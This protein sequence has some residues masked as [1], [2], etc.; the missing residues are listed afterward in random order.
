MSD[1]TIQSVA[2]IRNTLPP[3]RLHSVPTRKQ[4]AV[5]LV[6]ASNV[7]IDDSGAVA[8]RA[9]Q[10]LESANVAH[11]LWSNADQSICL[12]VEGSS[13]KRLMTVG[14]T[15][16]TLALGLTSGRRMA[17]V[18]VNDRV[19]F[20]NGA[21]TGVID[22]S[23]RSWGIAATEAPAVSAIAGQLGAGVY[24]AAYTHLRRD[25]QESGC[26]LA[27][28]IT[29][30]D[31]A[32]VRFTWNAPEDADVDEVALYLSE[33]NG[34]VMYQAGVYAAAALSADVTGPAL[35][36]PLATQWLDAPPPGQCLALHNGRI[37]IGAG[38]FV[39]GTGA[40]DFEHC[41]LRDYLALDGSAVRFI[42]GVTGG[43][44]IGTAQAVY[45]ASGERLESYTLRKVSTAPAV[46]GSVVTAN[47]A[48][49][50]GNAEL[51]PHEV[52]LFTTAEGVFMGLPDG[53]VQNLTQERYRFAPGAEGAAVFR[54]EPTR[55]QYLLVLPI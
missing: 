45:F 25:G 55:H 6:Q 9:G 35:A 20:S 28:Q 40:L 10:T 5:D 54:E 43:L 29:L 41:D 39:F 24:Q 32:G 3:E 15:V 8:R 16:V 53:S 11:S 44:F 34:M 46:I 48:V 7:D 27:A 30:G 22:G 31:G 26:A 21:Q 12:F 47:G 49:V 52:V 50:T 33:P 14:G 13:L 19:Y 17:F 36:L 42:V 38:A 51:S 37:F 1:F 4:P 2:G 23:V 18:E